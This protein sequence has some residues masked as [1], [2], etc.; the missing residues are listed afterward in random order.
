MGV[1]LEAKAAAQDA[2]AQQAGGAGF[3]QRGFEA[4]VDLEDSPWM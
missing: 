3:F 1:Q 2:F 4:F